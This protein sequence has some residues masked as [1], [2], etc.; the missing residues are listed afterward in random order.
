MFQAEGTAESEAQR[1]DSELRE[2]DGAWVWKGGRGDT[3]R[4]MARTSKA[5]GPL[6]QATGS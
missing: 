1:K 2:A 5:P 6:T 4:G 3:G